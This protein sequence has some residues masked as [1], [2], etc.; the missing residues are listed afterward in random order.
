[1]LREEI[2]DSALGAMAE[3]RCLSHGIPAL[4]LTGCQRAHPQ[5]AC[6]ATLVPEIASSAREDLGR[7]PYKPVAESMTQIAGDSDRKTPSRRG[8]NRKLRHYVESCPAAQD[9]PE[10][11]ASV[12][13]SAAAGP[14]GR[15]TRHPIVGSFTPDSRRSVRVRRI[16]DLP[17]PDRGVGASGAPA[18]RHVPE[19]WRC[20]RR[21]DFVGEQ[22]HRAQC[23]LRRKSGERRSCRRAQTNLSGANIQSVGAVYR[24]KPTVRFWA[25]IGPARVN[26]S[27]PG[28]PRPAIIN[29]T[30]PIQTTR[31]AGPR[32]RRRASAYDAKDRSRSSAVT[33]F[34]PS[35]TKNSS[36]RI[37]PKRKRGAWT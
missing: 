26:Q 8:G 16:P 3:V 9:I 23:E 7:P 5:G 12:G 27:I 24:K 32:R 19:R 15:R 33:M 31:T 34:I 29:S 10:L 18:V 36:T 2:P 17:G 37:Q 21:Q 35:M 1:M 14:Q 22:A 30:A 13:A 20:D 25:N 11:A 6:T 4:D 28:V